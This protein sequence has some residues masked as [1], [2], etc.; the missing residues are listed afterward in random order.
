MYTILHIYISTYLHIHANPLRIDPQKL[1]SGLEELLFAAKEY[2]AAEGKVVKT[3]DLLFIEH[4][5]FLFLYYLQRQTCDT[6]FNNETLVGLTR[7]DNL[8]YVAFSGVRDADMRSV[9]HGR[10]LLKLGAPVGQLP[11]KTAL[12]RTATETFHTQTRAL[13]WAIHRL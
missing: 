12:T 8:A 13:A 1:L 11:L 6:Y 9:L 2:E 10:K 5:C 7:S 4:K 3:Q